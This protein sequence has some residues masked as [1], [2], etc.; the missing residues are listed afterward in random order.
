MSGGRAVVATARRFGQG[1]RLSLSTP[2]DAL[3]LRRSEPGPR[4]VLEDWWRDRGWRGFE[5]RLSRP[6]R[7]LVPAAAADADTTATAEADAADADADAADADAAAATD[8]ADTAADADATAE[9]EA[10]AA[11]DA[12]TTTDAADAADLLL[13]EKRMHAGL[14]V[15]V[16]QG[17]YYGLIRVGWLRRVEGDEWELVGARVLVRAS[18]WRTSDGYLA[19][20]EAAA[21]G[22][23]T[24]WTLLPASAEPEP[25]WRGHMLRPIVADAEAWAV[26]CPRPP[27]WEP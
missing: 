26:E 5:G 2:P 14:T 10:D 16:S 17:T 11:T 1:G 22:P 9:A 19:L 8:A 24:A 6:P 12:T 25:V 21:Q 13:E 4:A 15:L 27:E 7:L 20:S 23:G 18:G 3:L